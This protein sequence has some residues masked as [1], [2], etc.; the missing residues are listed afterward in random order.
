MWLGHVAS[1]LSN[2]FSS[3]G[4]DVKTNTVS[5]WL[6]KIKAM[7]TGSPKYILPFLKGEIYFDNKSPIELLAFEFSYDLEESLREM[8]YSLIEHGIVP[9]KISR[10]A[11]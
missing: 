7:L 3:F 5:S 6:Y 8:G 11:L 2:E 9:D 1:T 10:R 4:Y